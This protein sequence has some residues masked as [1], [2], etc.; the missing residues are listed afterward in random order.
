M[1]PPPTA[2]PPTDA[3]PAR[4][5]VGSFCATF[6]KPEMLHIYRQINGLRRYRTVVF[7]LSRENADAFPFE[8]VEIMP[9]HP[10]RFFR[11]FIQ[12]KILHRPLQISE[13][14]AADMIVRMRSANIGL[15][16]V[17]FGHIGMY[18]L[19]LLRRAPW[20]VIVSFHG[21][22]AGVDLDK[23]AHLEALRE[24][25]E[26]ADL[27]LVR[28]QSL[29]DALI[30][31]GA[32]RECV[33]VQHTGIPLDAYPYHARDFPA[34]GGWHFVQACRLIPKKGIDTALR[35]FAQF[36][37]H[38]PGS[39]FTI[40]GE[41]PLGS[42]IPGLAR[43]LKIGKAVKLA[44]FLSQEALR[45]L[46]DSAHAF[47]HPSRVDSQG[48]QEGVPN[49][50][51]EA[52]AG[53]LPVLATRHGGIP[54][55]VDDMMGGFLVDENDA[56]ALAKAMLRLSSDRTHFLAMGRAASEAV[57]AR[58]EHAAQVSRLETH[59]DRVLA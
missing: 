9:K 32:I 45:A 41:G 13:G 33:A 19:P 43:E 56:E 40:A 4:P 37:A 20:P 47:V 50:M 8:S 21:A 57:R 29:A 52:M 31:I 49:S 10:G 7:T 14:E 17:Y 39:R 59:Y 53:G 2:P 24:V 26:R 30:Q 51:L 44:G 27:L 18:L 22:D 34:D 23:P 6:L 58:F 38:Y 3:A 55:A 28:S 25:F 12:K 48:N 1:N 11:K 16:H 5:V 42:E 36:H 54:E 15:L 35:A 46:Y